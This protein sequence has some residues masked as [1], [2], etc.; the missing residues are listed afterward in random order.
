MADRQAPLARRRLLRAAGLLP[1][2][3]LA[4]CVVAPYGSYHRPSSSLAGA[5]LG[6]AWCQGQSG[7]ETRLQADL[8]GVRLSV[9]TEPQPRSGPPGI[10][11]FAELTVPPGQLLHWQGE[12][13]VLVEGRPPA[14]SPQVSARR[15]LLLAAEQ[16]ADLVTL[17]PG[18]VAMD[19]QAP[20]G[21]LLVR[22]AAVAGQPA[23]VVVEGLAL[24]Q[25]GM[26]WVLPATPLARPASRTL[27]D[28]YRSDAEQAAVLARAG[29]CSLDTPQQACDNIVEFSSDS[30][31]GQDASL[32][33]RGR[34]YLARRSG[35]APRF[36]GELNLSPLRAGRLR[37]VDSAWQVRAADGGAAQ[38][39][40]SA[41]VRLSFDDRLDAGHVVPAAGV[42]TR[43][44]VQ[45]MLPEDVPTFD[46]L[47][48]A[49]ATAGRKVEPA[50]IRFERRRFD[51]GVEPFNC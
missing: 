11:L 50:R 14:V 35:A 25:A 28:V 27:P 5:Q 41:Q 46:F 48:P 18:S 19:P 37:V 9:R 12:P 29:A 20:Y 10:L 42:E 8:Q 13:R 39:L 2:A 3:S 30:H 24:E 23:R 34:W 31:R 21:S 7:P 36:E 16:W 6:K 4:G 43:I 22:P 44:A 49:F 17:R 47:L 45:A 38:P 51:G 1:L 40:R 33:W 26:R 15:S 32:R